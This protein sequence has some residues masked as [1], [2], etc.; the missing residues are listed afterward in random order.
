MKLE[1]EEVFKSELGAIKGLKAK[2]N[3]KEGTTPKCHKAR[4][5]PYSVRPKIDPELQKLENYGII[6]KVDW[7]ER[8]TP[9]VAVPKAKGLIRLCGD[10][11]GHYQSKIENRSVS[12][13]WDWRYFRKSR[14]WSPRPTCAK[15]TYN[16]KWK[17]SER[18]ILPSTR[19][20]VC[21]NTT[22]WCLASHLHLQSGKER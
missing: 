20:K 6:S 3:L 17:R 12:S 21:I 13:T 11:Q 9:V 7:S 16:T 19:T 22:D 4:R 14:S 8:A 2:L 10:F 1:F 5:E 18:N 15:H